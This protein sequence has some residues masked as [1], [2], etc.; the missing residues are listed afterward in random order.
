MSKNT[1][2]KVLI[3]GVLPPPNFG[4]SVMYKML[5]ESSFPENVQARFLNMHFWSYQTDKKVTCEKV[6][7]MIKY[8]G[9]YLAMI[10]F[11]RPRYVLYNSSFYKMPFLKDFLFC[12]TGIILGRRVVFHDFGQYVQELDEALS[13]WKRSMLR[14][15]LKYADGSIVMGENVRSAYKGLMDDTKIFVVPGVVE[16][17]HDLNVLPNRPAEHFLN[18][19]YFSHLSRD[20]GVF[21]AFDVAALVLQ[22]NSKAMITFAGPMESEQVAL[23]LE[24]LQ[25]EYPGRVRYLGYVEDAKERT[26]IFRGADVFMFTTLRDVFGLVLLHAMAEG[27]PVVVSREGT[28]PEIV[29]DGKTGFL[30]EKGKA[31]DFAQKIITLLS[32]NGLCQKMSIA[33]RARFESFYSLEQYGKRMVE[34]FAE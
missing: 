11:W 5:M 12:A 3:C 8:Y 25:K 10:I 6:F 2:P 7:K 34:V 29:I 22:A 4:H 13:G 15:M 27:K 23:G 18:I 17:T 16:D 30:C 31:E 24:H 28:I 19:L 33:S 9:Q 21:V 26:A 1:Q 32:D 20:K 14:W